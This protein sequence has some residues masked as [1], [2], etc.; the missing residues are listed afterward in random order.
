[1][2]KHNNN[3]NKILLYYHINYYH[4]NYTHYLHDIIYLFIF[5]HSVEKS[6]G[7]ASFKLCTMENAPYK[8][9]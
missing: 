1:M 5:N 4:I 6:F 8:C 2:R 3:K 7:S 9:Q